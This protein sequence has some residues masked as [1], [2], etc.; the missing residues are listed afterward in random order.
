MRDIATWL[1]GLGLGRYI[2]TFEQNEIDFDA[3]PYL[4]ESMLEKIGLPLGP[5]A[6][7]LGAISNLATPPGQISGEHEDKVTLE[8][9][10]AERRQITVMFCDLVDSTKLAGLMD[11]E[12]FG[13]VLQ[14]FQDSC[15]KVV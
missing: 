11:P 12:E 8:E 6:K 7:L 13:S 9:Q 10:E 15:G 14:A 3:L 2:E 1:E 4:T 5:R